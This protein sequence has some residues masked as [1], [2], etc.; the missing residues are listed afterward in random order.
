MGRKPITVTAAHI[1]QIEKMAGYGMTEASIAHIIGMDP[2]TLRVK[3]GTDTRIA[4]A[5]ERG[6][7]K[8]EQQVGK[9]LYLAAL[10]PKHKG[11]L[12]A[13]IWLEK[14]RAGRIEPRHESTKDI[15]ANE[16]LERF[17]A[18]VSKLEERAK[19]DSGDTLGGVHVNDRGPALGCVPQ[20][21]AP[22]SQKALPTW[23]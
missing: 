11:Q 8:A 22:N 10:D 12:T 18:I 16:T 15:E 5:L 6:K 21:A 9:A 3:K 7:A 4:S 2:S 1:T 14:T 13:I 19:L 23:Q 17:K 20:P